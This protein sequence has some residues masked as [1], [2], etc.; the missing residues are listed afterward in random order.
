[1]VPT[2]MDGDS[3]DSLGFIGVLHPFIPWR[4]LS[5]R[6]SF[7]NGNRKSDGL[8]YLYPVEKSI[9]LIEWCGIIICFGLVL[10]AEGFNTAIEIL[11]DRICPFKDESIKLAKDITRFFSIYYDLLN[12][13]SPILFNT[14]I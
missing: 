1:M 14:M 9:S 7:W 3:I 11:T 10:A 12:K 8:Y 2:E 6:Y 4:T 13:I 5:I